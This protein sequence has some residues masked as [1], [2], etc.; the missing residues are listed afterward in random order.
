ME[1]REELGFVRV[2]FDFQKTIVTV[3]ANRE[4]FVKDFIETVEIKIE[5]EAMLDPSLRKGRGLYKT[6]C[7]EGS[8][9]YCW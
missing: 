8:T 7:V 5:F 9:K 6:P 4:D 2:V 1:Q 3:V